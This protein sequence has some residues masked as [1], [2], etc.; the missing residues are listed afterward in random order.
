[1]VNHWLN[2]YIMGMMIVPMIILYLDSYSGKSLSQ[3]KSFKTV[4]YIISIFWWLFLLLLFLSY[5]NKNN[6]KQD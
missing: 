2:Y 1:M 3:E 4:I 6:I 5:V